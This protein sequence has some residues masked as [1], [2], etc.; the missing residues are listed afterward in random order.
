MTVDAKDMN[1]SKRRR[2]S[3]AEARPKRVLVIDIGGSKI[4]ILATGQT[5]PR[6]AASGKRMTPGRMVEEVKGLVRGW[7]YDAISIGYPGLVG[8]QGPRSEPGNLSS[9]WVGFDYAAGF[10]CPVRI[11]NDAAMQ[12]LGSYDGGRMLFLGLGT[13]LGST[14]VANNV[15]VTL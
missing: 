14:L 2:R 1:G 7:S 11:V 12:A 9:G 5:E 15:V 8:E 10:G 13:G 4:K 6:K 3:V